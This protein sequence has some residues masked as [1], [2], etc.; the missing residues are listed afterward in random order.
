MLLTNLQCTLTS[1]FEIK[2]TCASNKVTWKY[3]FKV[4]STNSYLENFVHEKDVQIN[5]L[6]LTYHIVNKIQFKNF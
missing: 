1:F 3:H 5:S 2:I 4:P 6:S